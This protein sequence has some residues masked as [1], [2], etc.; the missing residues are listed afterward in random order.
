MNSNEVVRFLLLVL[1][2]L[3]AVL[4]AKA[5]SPLATASA[6]DPIGSALRYLFW[7]ALFVALLKFVEGLRG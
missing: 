4:A 7:G 6:V 3:V 1:T 5:I 2:V